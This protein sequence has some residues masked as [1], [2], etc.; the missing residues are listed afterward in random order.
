[1]AQCLLVADMEKKIQAQ[2]GRLAVHHPELL[3]R[4]NNH[5]LGV[6]AIVTIHL[7]TDLRKPI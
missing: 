7:M 4:E 5:T 2:W 3:P 6:T 1:M